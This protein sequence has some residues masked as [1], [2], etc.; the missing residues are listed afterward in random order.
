M[1][2]AEKNGKSLLREI[3]RF[4][5]SK[6]RKELLIRTRCSYKMIVERTNQASPYTHVI[7]VS[8]EIKVHANRA[9]S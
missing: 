9:R 4:T 3:K 2:V 1:Y 5:V 7:V 6:M 8:M